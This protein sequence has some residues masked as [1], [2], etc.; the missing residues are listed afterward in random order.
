MSVLFVC[1]LNKARSITAERMYRRTP[2]ICVRSAGISDRAAHQV[3]E[4]DLAWADRVIVFAPEHERW[5]RNTFTGDLPEIVDVG[6]TDDYL[7]DDSEL[8]AELAEVL[9]P[10]LGHP[11]RAP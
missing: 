7:A 3:V 1:T 8:V 10:V 2:G 4:A 9:P 6:I 5:I 11:P